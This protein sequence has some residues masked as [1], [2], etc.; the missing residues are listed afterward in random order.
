MLPALSHTAYLFNFFATFRLCCQHCS[1]LTLVAYTFLGLY[2]GFDHYQATKAILSPLF[3]VA[4][5]VTLVEPCLLMGLS[6]SCRILLD[7]EYEMDNYE[8]EDEGSLQADAALADISRMQSSESQ[9]SS[10]SSS[11]R[12]RGRTAYELEMMERGLTLPED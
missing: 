5:L 6:V 9:T 4:T 3:A 1:D 10:A 11:R 7:S 2:I 8:D 12:P